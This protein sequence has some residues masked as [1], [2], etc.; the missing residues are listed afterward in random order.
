MTKAKPL[1]KKDW[2][3]FVGLPTLLVAVAFGAAFVSRVL[4]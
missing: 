1:W 4:A 2:F 3:W